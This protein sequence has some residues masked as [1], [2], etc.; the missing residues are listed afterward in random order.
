MFRR[1]WRHAHLNAL[2]SA[3]TVASTLPALLHGGEVVAGIIITRGRVRAADRHAVAFVLFQLVVLVICSFPDPFN[4]K[5]SRADHNSEVNI[6][7]IG[8]ASTWC[9]PQDRDFDLTADAAT[10]VKLAANHNRSPRYV[11]L[12]P[13]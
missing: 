2:V 1:L 4:S 5:E 7:N 8:A 10:V 3:A 12:S 9:I 13:S 6:Q 11:A